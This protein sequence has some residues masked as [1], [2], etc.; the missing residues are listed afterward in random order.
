MRYEI[1]SSKNIT[2]YRIAR[3][4]VI[5][6]L[7]VNLRKKTFDLR[8]IKASSEIRSAVFS[9]LPKGATLPSS[10]PTLPSDRK[11]FSERNAE[12]IA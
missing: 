1:Q 5:F 11:K 3:K 8:G 2:A 7:N 9:D 4:T 6:H 12:R 10:Y